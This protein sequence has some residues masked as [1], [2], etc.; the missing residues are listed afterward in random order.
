MCSWNSSHDMSLRLSII[1]APPSG[2]RTHGVAELEPCL[3][4]LRFAI[5]DG[6]VEHSGNFIMLVSL[7]IV[8]HENEAVARRQVGDGSFQGQAVNGP[9][10]GQVRGA[11]TSAWSFFRRR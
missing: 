11:K 5:T 1:T 8:Q 6:T 9:R 10:Q 4:Q 3:V 7:D 2:K